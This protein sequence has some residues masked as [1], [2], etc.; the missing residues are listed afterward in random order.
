VLLGTESPVALALGL[1]VTE[2]KGD[3]E[4]HRAWPGEIE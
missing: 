1:Q 2:F 4:L 3:I